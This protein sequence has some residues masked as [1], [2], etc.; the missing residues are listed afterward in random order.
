M[1]APV[2]CDTAMQNAECRM[3][4]GERGTGNGDWGMAQAVLTPYFDEDLN[5]A[6]AATG[7]FQEAGG[8]WGHK[9]WIEASRGLPAVSGREGESEIGSASTEFSNNPGKK[10]NPALNRQT[11][12]PSNC[13]TAEAAGLLPLLGVCLAGGIAAGAAGVFAAVTIFSLFLFALVLCGVG[14]SPVS[15]WLL[16]VLSAGVV[17]GILPQSASPTAPSRRGQGCY[18]GG[19]FRLFLP[20]PR[21]GMPQRGWG[22]YFVPI[23]LGMLVFSATGLVAL[24]HPFVAPYGLA[25]TGGRAKLWFLSCGIPSGFFTDAVWRLLEPAYPPGC[26]A[27]TFGCYG[28]SGICGDWLTQLA[29]CVFSA[30]AAAFL[31]SR[32]T[33]LARLWL[34]LLFLTPVALMTTGQFYP[35]PLMALGVLVGWER[36]RDGQF[37][38]WLLLGAAG[39]FKNEGLM[40]LFAAWL[41]WRIVAG[42]D[43]ARMRDLAV[44]MILPLAWHV[45]CRLAG[46][47][48]NDYVAPWRLSPLRGLRALLESLRLAFA[49]PWRSGFAYPAAFVAALIPSIRRKARPLLAALLFAVFSV[50]FFCL[51]YACSTADEAWHLSTSLPRLLWTPAL[52]L[53]REVAAICK[54]NGD[55][56]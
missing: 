23:L 5:A 49:R 31:A 52:I 44:A 16:V 39:W 25:I 40:F 17:Y 53:A 55:G 14:A 33:G 12:K 34:A 47:S 20:P 46:A 51:A 50:V 43:H 1:P 27:L 3:Q 38:G 7:R 22:E 8:V 9:L 29:P 30:V 41:A 54:R 37:G 56:L 4:N 24:A 26:A 6:I 11:V 45:G 32:T 13:Q 48:L 15:V 19:F 42:G 28:A 2:R 35:E 21:G 36:I 10:Q 18:K